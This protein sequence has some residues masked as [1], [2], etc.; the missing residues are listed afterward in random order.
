MGLASVSSRNG[1]MSNAEESDSEIAG[2]SQSTHFVFL[3]FPVGLEV[4]CPVQSLK[5]LVSSP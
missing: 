3:T 2:T 5:H 4:P 1:R